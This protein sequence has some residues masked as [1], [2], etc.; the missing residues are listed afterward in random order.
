MQ[1][2]YIEISSTIPANSTIYGLGETTNSNGIQLRR[3]GWPFVLWN[4]DSPASLFDQNVYGSH[5]F[6]MEVRAGT[7]IP[8]HA[9]LSSTVGL[10]EACSQVA[11]FF[12]LYNTHGLELALWEICHFP[13]FPVG[14]NLGWYLGHGYC[15]KIQ[16]S[17][18][19]CPSFCSLHMC[20]TAWRVA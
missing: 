4:R 10:L 6:Y 18:L 3:T 1:D 8:R 12:W 16:W 17:C 13:L 19:A 7:K 15:S 9:S 14:R 5:P 11:H 20:P 2:Q